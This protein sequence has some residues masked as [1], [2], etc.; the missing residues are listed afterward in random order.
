MHPGSAEHRN[1]SIAH[2]LHALQRLALEPVAQIAQFPVGVAATDELALDFE[3][4]LKVCSGWGD[5]DSHVAMRLAAIDDL[6]GSMSGADQKERWTDEALAADP[7]WRRV[8][9]MACEALRQAGWPR[10]LPPTPEEDGTTY[11]R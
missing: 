8:R 7:G 10:A 9:A 4:W 3:H 11:V 5:V 2:L 6:L 1:A